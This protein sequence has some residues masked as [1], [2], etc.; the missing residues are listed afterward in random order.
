MDRQNA[1]R[2]AQLH[3]HMRPDQVSQ[4]VHQPHA[5]DLGSSHNLQ[6]GVASIRG[7][8]AKIFMHGNGGGAKIQCTALEGGQNFSARKLAMSFNF[9]LSPAADVTLSSIDLHIQSHN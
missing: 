3:C 9:N 8:G 1:L 5:F 7:G 2:P 6:V 4:R